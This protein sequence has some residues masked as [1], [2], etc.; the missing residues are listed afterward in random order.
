MDNVEEKEGRNEGRER[1][2]QVE[3]K[4]GKGKFT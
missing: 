1:G 2:E 3:V 4:L